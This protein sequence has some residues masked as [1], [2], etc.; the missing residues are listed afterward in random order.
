M[1]SVHDKEEVKLFLD[2]LNENL[3]FLDDSII[4]LEKNP[5]NP[6]TL[7]DI[8]RVAHTIK[9]SAGFLDLKNLVSLGHAMENVFQEFKSGGAK[10]GKDVIDTLLECKDAIGK[11][12]HLLGKG[13]DSS[14]INTEHLI[15]KVNLF[16]QNSKSTAG[17]EVKKAPVNI[18]YKSGDAKLAPE[19]FIEG[20]ILV[21]VWISTAELAPSIRAFLVQKRLSEHGE[22]VRQKPTEDE[23]DAENFELPLD[24]E[25]RYWIKT[26]SSI[27]EIESTARADL[28]DKVSVLPQEIL[29]AM[30][31][32]S[33]DDENEAESQT[34][35]MEIDTSDSVRIPVQSLDIM[36]NLVGELVIA[37]SGFTQIQ[38]TLRNFPEL[39]NLFKDVRDRTKDL[40]RISSE[41]QELVMESRLVPISQVFNRFRRFVRDY[42]SKSGKKILMTM[43]GESTE[44]DKKITDEI[45]K[46]LTHLVRNSLDHG[47][48]T[49]QERLASGKPETGTL[50]LE[51]YQEGNYINIIIK[52]DGRGLNAEKIIQKA[53]EKHIITPEE[54]M[55][56]THDDVKNLIF[57]SG[58]STKEE[59]DEMSGRGVGMDVV[60]SSV[61]DLNGTI[62][63]DSIS[64]QGTTIT[65][66]LPLTLAILNALIV[67]VGAEKYCIPMSAIVETQKVDTKNFL[68]VDSNEM[69]RLRDKLIPVIN[70]NKIFPSLTEP[71]EKD[72]LLKFAEQKKAKQRA[73]EHPVIVVDYHN[74]PI[75]IMVDQF[76]LR[77]EVVIKS[78]AEHYRT[79]DGIS[80]ASILGD[81]SIILII[82]V[83]GVIQ[84]FKTQ[85]AKVFGEA[86]T[87]MP[88]GRQNLK[89]VMPEIIASKITSETSAK[90]SVKA[91]E[92]QSK[93]VPQI[94]PKVDVN[95]KFDIT[96]ISSLSAAEFD[97]LEE[98]EIIKKDKE[99]EVPVSATGAAKEATADE[100][101]QDIIIYPDPVAQHNITSAEPLAEKPEEIRE[102]MATEVE[103]TSSSETLTE[104]L[105][106]KSEDIEETSFSD[107]DIGIFETSP[108]TPSEVKGELSEKPVEVSDLTDEP[109]DTFD[110]E[111]ETL[112]PV[113]EDEL[114]P[115]HFE[116]PSEVDD[117]IESFDE[118]GE[119]THDEYVEI[120]DEPITDLSLTD[121]ILNGSQEISHD[122]SNLEILTPEEDFITLEKEDEPVSVLSEKISHERHVDKID[123]HDTDENLLKEKSRLHHVEHL[124]AN[125]TNAEEKVSD[126]TALDEAEINIVDDTENIRPELTAL[127]PDDDDFEF[128]VSLDDTVTIKTG[129]DIVDG[130]SE[131]RLTDHVSEE[132]TIYDEGVSKLTTSPSAEITIDEIEEEMTEMRN[133]DPGK[134]TKSDGNA[135]EISDFERL[136]M[137]MDS[138]EIADE[139]ENSGTYESIALSHFNKDDYHMEKLY[140]LLEGKSPDLIKDWLKNGNEKAI[141]G[142]K[143]LTG[144]Q[145]IYPGQTRAK[146]YTIDKLNVFIERF[147]GDDL[148]VVGLALPI[149]PLNGMIY[150][151]L[152]HANAQNMASMLYENAQMTPPDVID[153]EPLMEVTNILGSAFTNTLTQITDIPIEPGIPEILENN[154]LLIESMNEHLKK[155]VEKNI[156]YIEN[157]FL[158]GEKEVLAELIMMIPKII[159]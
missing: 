85:R 42:S 64:G 36:L 142:I 32:F 136:K 77:Q 150:F 28:V 106:K 50:H 118:A 61:E 67:Q 60:K 116:Q 145:N 88:V 137:M 71:K 148:P 104:I 101:D 13:E 123:L 144:H 92:I 100:T 102:E 6:E 65:I 47:L 94:T 34:Q 17:E 157:E 91:V 68:T 97:Q 122:E 27:E 152:T 31:S 11:I 81:G 66:K 20:A 96:D 127:S 138:G 139:E 120:F 1:V 21:R 39:Q 147:K 78:L 84:L 29:K 86:A 119:V 158:W 114:T 30:I 3:N 14:R 51:A 126:L 140:D 33:Q 98:L 133:Y 8:F 54:A 143:S 90:Q 121:R 12:G 62:L 25:V 115:E 52:D 155:S 93:P 38:E 128:S 69:V 37:N 89:M 156:L 111:V 40:V 125:V 72:K 130:S 63:I 95:K 132:Q 76:L 109:V 53:I 80:G 49:P 46:P 153:F 99:S 75:A 151:I 59:I 43:T 135:A 107:L 18:N 45:I 24:R 108:E 5:G 10:V 57:N 141:E 4:S 2:E 154:E 83:H 87:I 16:L 129:S 48:E 131:Q 35:K 79:I 23:M 124:K 15:K 56:I 7:E 117:E 41:I 9:G 146:K 159:E 26:Q 105:T 70:L 82:D 112:I 58:F 73:D 22:I 103:V 19:D 44:L 149:M 55:S 113:V 110:N 74:S 134:E